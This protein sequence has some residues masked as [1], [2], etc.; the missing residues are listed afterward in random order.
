MSLAGVLRRKQRG[1]V[2][3]KGWVEGGSFVGKLR[4]QPEPLLGAG[5]ELCLGSVEK[6][7]EASTRSVAV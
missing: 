1:C 3:G 4:S 7:V 6:N 5:K 2:V